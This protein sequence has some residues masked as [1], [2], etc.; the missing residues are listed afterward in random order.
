M[1]VFAK[2]AKSGEAAG[3]LPRTVVGGELRVREASRRAIL[4][5]SLV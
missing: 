4:A 2:A 3:P 5:G 1:T